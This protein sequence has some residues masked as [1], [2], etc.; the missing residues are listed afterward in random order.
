MKKNDKVTLKDIEEG[1]VFK[2]PSGYYMKVA[3]EFKILKEI[4]GSYY[5]V[6]VN[7]ET[8]SIERFPS[9][10]IVEA[11]CVKVILV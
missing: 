11:V 10:K 1:K 5:V 6:G 2:T 4:L 8:G 9:S 7:L 3:D